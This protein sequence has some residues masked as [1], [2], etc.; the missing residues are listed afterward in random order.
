MNVLP[1]TISFLGEFGNV[2]LSEQILQRMKG[3]LFLLRY[4][5]QF[6]SKEFSVERYSVNQSP[7]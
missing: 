1:V 3:G 6:R 5:S 2:F 7:I 4:I